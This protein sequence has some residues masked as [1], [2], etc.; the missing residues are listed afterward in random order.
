MA[1]R[2]S[3]VAGQYS[4]APSVWAAIGHGFWQVLSRMPESVFHKPTNGFRASLLVQSCCTDLPAHQHVSRHSEVPASAVHGGSTAGCVRRDT[5]RA[6]LALRLQGCHR[7][8]HCLE[9]TMPPHHSALR[10]TCR[11]RT[12]SPPCSRCIPADKWARAVH[13]LADPDRGTFP[14]NE[15]HTG[16]GGCG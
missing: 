10:C 5:L 8:V 12:T 14:C 16:N 6:Q 11:W 7:R 15:G 4:P 2:Y 9:R 13:N 3:P 1:T